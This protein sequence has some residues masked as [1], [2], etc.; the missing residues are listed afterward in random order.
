ML[1]QVFLGF[2]INHITFPLI[3]IQQRVKL[4][5]TCGLFREL[6]LLRKGLFHL[7]FGIFHLFF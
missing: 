5:K 6:L 1:F 2:C 7:R 4:R 3:D